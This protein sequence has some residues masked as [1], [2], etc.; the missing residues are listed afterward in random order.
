MWCVVDVVNP[1][2]PHAA[3]IVYESYTVDELARVNLIFERQGN[4]I[5]YVDSFAKADQVSD[6]APLEAAPAEI[7]VMGRSNCGK[8]TLLNAVLGR[9]LANVSQR[10]GYTRT[11][12]RF[13]CPPFFTLIDVPGYGY[14]EASP[15]R[16]KQWGRMEDAFF[17]DRQAV[18][19]F[20]LLIDA[21]RGITDLDEQ[22]LERLEQNCRSYQLILTKA[23][24]LTPTELR[25]VVAKTEKRV[26][27][28]T[29]PGA[30]PTV[31]ATSGLVNNYGVG[32]L[33]AVLLEAAGQAA[34]FRD[35]DTIVS[36]EARIRGIGESELD[37]KLQRPI[38]NN[39]TRQQLLD[40]HIPANP[41]AGM[42]QQELLGGIDQQAKE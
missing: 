34:R 3:K 41:F 32:I 17:T 25:N 2:Q 4:T 14:A 21:R 40:R 20:L 29:Q 19:R 10:P 30:V 1:A 26:R 7:V 42:S 23:D 18:S 39:L 24:K 27:S 13:V 12:N 5:D 37:E 36:G 16:R 8:S 38:Q 6:V 28:K 9:H 22:R 31:I 33:R 15:E 11:A 35:P